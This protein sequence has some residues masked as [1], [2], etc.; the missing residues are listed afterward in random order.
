[1]RRLSVMITVLALSLSCAG[2]I[3]LPRLPDGSLNV[4]LLLTWAQDGIDAD[5]AFDATS[6]VCVIGDDVIMAIRSKDPKDVKQALIDAELRF[7]VLTSY[8]DW[9]VKLL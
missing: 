1:M 2:G 4:P 6:A 9:L 7:P 3:H 8:L 5:C